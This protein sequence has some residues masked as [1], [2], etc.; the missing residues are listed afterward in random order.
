MINCKFIT[1]EYPPMING[2]AGTYAAEITKT[3]GV[4]YEVFCPN[5]EETYG[6]N[7]SKTG[8]RE[9]VHLYH[10]N[11]FS[12]APGDLVH[13]NG[14]SGYSYLGKKPLVVTI[15]HVITDANLRSFFL[16]QKQKISAKKAD[17]VITHSKYSKKEIIEHFNISDKKK[18]EV[19]PLGAS[20][21]FLEEKPSYSEPKFILV[22]NGVREE[23]KR[24]D[25]VIDVVSEADI[26]KIVT[27]GDINSKIAKKYKKKCS[28]LDIKLENKGFISKEKLKKL[29]REAYALG[30]PS[31]QESFGLVVLESMASGTPPL[32]RGGA[33]AEILNYKC[34]IKG[35]DKEKWRKYLNELEKN[36]QKEAKNSIEQAKNFSWDSTR[37][38]TKS[39]YNKI[40]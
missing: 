10:L 23:R 13:A 14:F 21:E 17:K 12:R 39:V 34:G 9:L 35:E 8:L 6:Y 31:T 5:N 11:N 27:T 24:L 28:K 22:P 3:E 29:Y 33:P 7:F 4:N 36:Y 26:N 37:N 30:F 25:Y 18:I 40:I 1:N 32:V 2:G 15:H 19:I 20:I 38:K 16:R